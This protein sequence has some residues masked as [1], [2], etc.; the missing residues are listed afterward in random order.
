MGGG[1]SRSIYPE[2]TSVYRHGY[3]QGT[4]TRGCKIESKTCVH[5]YLLR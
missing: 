1:M 3:S 2:V 5:G 4:C